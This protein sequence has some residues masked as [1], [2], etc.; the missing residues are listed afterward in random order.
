MFE[1]KDKIESAFISIYFIEQLLLVLAIF[2]YPDLINFWVSV[3]PLI[4]LTTIA[5]E[6]LFLSADFKEQLLAERL[7]QNPQEK[8]RDI[9]FKDL[10]ESYKNIIGDKERWEKK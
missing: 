6:K 9:N 4:F 1:K 5:F 8:K 3:F 2:K 7:K 10:M